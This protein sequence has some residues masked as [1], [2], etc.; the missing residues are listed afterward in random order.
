MLKDNNILFSKDIKEAFKGLI[1]FGIYLVMS[2]L[3]AVPLLLLNIDYNSW[4]TTS[5]SIYMIFYCI[6]MMIILYLLFRK[7]LNS[8]FKEFV[9]DRHAFFKKYINYWFLILG[10]MLVSNYIIY[11]TINGIA[12]NEES[13]RETLEVAP[14]YTYFAA[15]IFA[16]FVEELVFRN[17]LRKIFKNKYLFIFIS[18]F[19][20]G[21]MHVFTS[22]MQLTDLL[23]LIPYCTPGFVFAYI[24]VKSD[25]IF[26]T[27]SI[28][29]IH[30]F[31]L[32][33]L[34]LVLFL[35]GAV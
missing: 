5:K 19:V 34:Q 10:V 21:G 20:F 4:S 9:A 33:T 14:V 15:V 25:N 2:Y 1:G 27:I 28:H 35:I 29:F 7:E 22:G 31:V 24:L 11:T 3:K 30:N 26:N 17:C 8:K 18:G 6:F 16:P 12:T 32:M 13:I 23:Y